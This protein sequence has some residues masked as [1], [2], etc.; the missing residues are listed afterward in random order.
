MRLK[1][2]FLFLVVNVLSVKNTN[3]QSPIF[4]FIDTSAVIAVSTSQSPAHWY[5]EIYN[6]TGVDTLLRWKTRF[7]NIPSA[8][9]INFDDQH[10]NYPTIHDGDSA[11]L[12]LLQDVFNAQKLIIGAETA[13]TPGWGIVYFDIF[14]P[15]E[16]SEKQ[17]IEYHFRIG[18]LGLQQ[19]ET[20][21][22]FLFGSG[23][24][25]TR[26]GSPM[27]CFFYSFDGKL[28]N[29]ISN[30]GLLN[31][32]QI[33]EGCDLIHVQAGDKSLTWKLSN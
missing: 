9:N 26:N 5:I 23:Q 28:I 31:L 15:S 10:T 29:E 3:A 13:Q 7:E 14:N 22:F 18:E 19:K 27:T 16:R 24:L 21:T 6:D 12:V 2:L 20:T 33:P 1:F 8:W 11:D 4:H 17:T 25:Q 30:N 32:S